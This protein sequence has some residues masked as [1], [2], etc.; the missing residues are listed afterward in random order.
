MDEGRIVSE[1]VREGV[2]LSKYL[3]I[4][5]SKKRVSSP[6]SDRRTFGA[7]SGHT[8]EECRAIEVADGRTER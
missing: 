6:A 7:I 3:D 4:E 5:R 8:C 1:D 2:D